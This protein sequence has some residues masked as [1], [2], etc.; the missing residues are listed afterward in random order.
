MKKRKNKLLKCED[1]TEE[2]MHD[3][4]RGLIGLFRL[5]KSREHKGRVTLGGNWNTKYPIGV[6]RVFMRLA[7]DIQAGDISIL[8]EFIKEND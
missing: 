5:R 8:E 7:E 4:G 1:F 3:I 6:F 2:Q